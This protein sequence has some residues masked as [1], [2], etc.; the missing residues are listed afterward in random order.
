[1]SIGNEHV[2]RSL[3]ILQLA[4][5]FKLTKN[6]I[7]MVELAHPKD[8]QELSSIISRQLARVSIY[9]TNLVA[10]NPGETGDFAII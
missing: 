10:G 8:V 2:K 6:I 7:E 4:I 3:Q 1:M 5:S 9:V